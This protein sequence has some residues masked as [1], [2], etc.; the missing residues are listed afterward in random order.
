MRLHR[1]R[2]ETTVAAGIL[3]MLATA[4]PADA[5]G[6]WCDRGAVSHR[7]AARVYGY[8]AYIAP[9]PAARVSSRSILLTTPPPPGGSTTLDLP[10]FT[11]MQGILESPVPS[12]RPAL[13]GSYGPAYGYT[14]GA[15][16]PRRLRR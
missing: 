11:S 7:R 12:S 9:R 13:L 3:L 16:A 2:R 8:G 4:A 6:W 14:A 5:C 1:L 15:G 10:G